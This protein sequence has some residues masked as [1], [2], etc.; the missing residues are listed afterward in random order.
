[1]HAAL[2]PPWRIGGL[3]WGFPHNPIPRMALVVVAGLRFRW[4]VI[5][6]ED[7]IGN[8]AFEVLGALPQRVRKPLHEWVSAHRDEIE[9]AWVRVMISKG[10]LTITTTGKT[11][12]VVA[13]PGLPH[14]IQ[15]TLDFTSCPVWLDDD[16]VSIEDESTLVLGVRNPERAQVHVPLGSVIWTGNHDGSHA[17]T[18]PF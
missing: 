6:L 9:D 15:R 14:F 13:Y 10:W 17:H 7:D 1:M 4:A 8:R 3:T 16:D 18:I 12:E 5:W 11:V 2:E